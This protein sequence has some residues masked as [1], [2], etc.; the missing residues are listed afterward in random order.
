DPASVA[1]PV[2]AAAAEPNASTQTLEPAP[3]S[4][5]KTRDQASKRHTAARPAIAKT[6]V[7]RPRSRPI[8]PPPVESSAPRRSLNA[9]LEATK[10]TNAPTTSIDWNSEPAE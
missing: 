4:A 7:Q 6:P 3:P 10:P 9:M 5:S 8:S 1:M 2:H